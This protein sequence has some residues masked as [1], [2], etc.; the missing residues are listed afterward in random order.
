M[1]VEFQRI[2]KRDKKA[3]SSE[4]QKEIEEN[5]DGKACYLFKK[6]GEVKGTFHARMGMVKN[7]TVRI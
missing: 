2:T 6:T 4:Q 3:F 5:I 1:N 7:R